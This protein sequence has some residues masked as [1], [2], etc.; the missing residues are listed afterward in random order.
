[1]YK[2]LEIPFVKLSMYTTGYTVHIPAN[3]H[4]I[5]VYSRTEYTKLAKVGNT[6]GMLTKSANRKSANY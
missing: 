3:L 5:V 4:E 6:L 2:N 1:M